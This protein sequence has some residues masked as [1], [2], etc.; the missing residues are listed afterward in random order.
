MNV[1]S[2]P[3]LRPEGFPEGDPNLLAA[4]TAALGQ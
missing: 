2:P 3:V 1:P 4:I